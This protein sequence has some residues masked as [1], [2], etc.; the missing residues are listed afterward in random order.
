MLKKITLFVLICQ[1][2]LAA[3]GQNTFYEK[4][5]D[6]INCYTTKA[7]LY[8]FER[9]SV[10]NKIGNNCTYPNITSETSKVKENV[11]QG[12][13]QRI[14]DNAAAINAYKQKIET[15]ASPSEYEYLLRD[16]QSYAI[17]SLGE[18]CKPY[19]GKS[20]NVCS[21]LNKDQI[22]LQ[23][24]INH[25]IGQA[26]KNIKNPTAAQASNNTATSTATGTTTQRPAQSP[27]T[28]TTNRTRNISAENHTTADVPANN[29]NANNT[30]M[31]MTT[32]NAVLF[33]TLFI[34]IAWL[35][36]ENQELRE[37]IEDIK[38]LLK[39][40]TKKK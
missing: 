13:R 21:N 24:D 6:E 15:S 17:A 34:V 27:E 11:L 9:S 8:N 32:V 40:L 19:L 12:Y 33:I 10:A 3:Q 39:V 26:L 4:A 37:Q 5:V 29:T 28:T 23:G 16:L 20:P 7:L 36:K 14:L 22:T 31:G 38:T 2:A 35:F 30:T 25:I 1:L 18:V